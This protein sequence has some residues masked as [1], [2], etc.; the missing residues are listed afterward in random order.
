VT[1]NFYFISETSNHFSIRKRSLKKIYRVKN[2]GV[3]V[4]KIRTRPRVIEEAFLFTCQRSLESAMA[5]F[6]KV[7]ELLL[8]SYD[9][10]D[11]SED[12]F[13]LLYDANSSKNPDFPY[14]NYEHFDLQE[15]NESE[16]LAE[17]R[18]FSKKGHTYSRR[19]I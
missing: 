10:G 4:L 18:Q 12:E 6:R 7:C 19:G 9:D 8:V 5:T 1:P 11:I 16:C 15:F 14:Q 3:N 2:F 17:F 13:L